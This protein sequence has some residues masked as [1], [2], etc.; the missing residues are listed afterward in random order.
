MDTG[1]PFTK[2]FFFFQTWLMG[3]W[4]YMTAGMTPA[5]QLMFGLSV[6]VALST[7]F[8]NLMAGIVN[9]RKN[10]LIDEFEGANRPLLRRMLEAMTTKPSPL[11][12]R[13]E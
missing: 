10:G 8:S 13:R 7:V 12:E 11:D 6:M 3:A 1:N 5:A 9:Y 4:E 2:A